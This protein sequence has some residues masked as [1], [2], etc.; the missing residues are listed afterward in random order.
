MQNMHVLNSRSENKSVFR[1]SIMQNKKLIFGIIC[2]TTIHILAS[3]TPIMRKILRI[4]ALRLDEMVMVFCMATF[5]IFAS[6]IEKFI[7]RKRE[8]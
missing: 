7:R 6:E 5:L 3:Y 1:H 2:A 4:E 8:K